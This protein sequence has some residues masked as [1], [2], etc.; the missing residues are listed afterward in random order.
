MKNLHRSKRKYA[1]NGGPRSY[2]HFPQL[3]V[4]YRIKSLINTLNWRDTR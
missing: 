3:G 1:G 4:I 2:R